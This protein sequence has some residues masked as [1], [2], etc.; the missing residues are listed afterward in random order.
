MS[1]S[2]AP[3]Q[4]LAAPADRASRLRIAAL[5]VALFVVVLF[6]GYV[7]HWSWT[8]INGHTATLWEWLN[9]LLLPMVVGFLPIWLSRRTRLTPRHKRSGKLGASV[10]A[11]IVFFGYVVP[12]AWTG[13]VGNTLWDWF[14]LIALPLALALT[15]VYAELRRTW[16]RR[17]TVIAAAGLS[18]LAVIALGGYLGDWTWTGFHNNTVWDWLHLLLLPLLIPSLVVP[19]LRPIAMAGVTFVGQ[20]EAAK[21]EPTGEAEAAKAGQTRDADGGADGSGSPS[22]TAEL[23]QS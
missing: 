12:W 15:P 23:Q 17:Y 8:G 22:A 20:E 2:S 10:F 1:D 19:A 6:G 14:R 16:T 9:L 18:C 7:G 4:T 11:L 21:P 13:F 3:S 5:A